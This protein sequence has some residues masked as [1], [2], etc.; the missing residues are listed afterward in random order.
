MGTGTTD[1]TG[2]GEA[3]IAAASATGVNGSHRAH[4]EREEDPVVLVLDTCV[5]RCLDAACGAHVHTTLLHATGEA[6]P[7]VGLTVRGMGDAQRELGMARR[8][9]R[10]SARGNRG[11][12]SHAALLSRLYDLDGLRR[13]LAGGGATRELR[14]RAGRRAGRRGGDIGAL[15]DTP[16]AEGHRTS[17]FT[18]RGGYDWCCTCDA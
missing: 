17:N 13:R 6:P 5:Q 4:Q 11:E 8:V 18:V 2:K 10:Q 7:G 15:G 3:R 14:E 12:R 9:A 16:G 1:G